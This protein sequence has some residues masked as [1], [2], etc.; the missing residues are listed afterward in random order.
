MKATKIKHY[1]CE[2]RIIADN[3]ETYV[4]NYDGTQGE[5]TREEW[6]EDEIVS[7]FDSESQEQI[8]ADLAMTYNGEFFA[9]E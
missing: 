5:Y 6:K 3:G 2:L 7:M 1:P 8:L 4:I 9:Q